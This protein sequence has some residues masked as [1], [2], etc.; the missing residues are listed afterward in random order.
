MASSVSVKTMTAHCSSAGTAE[1]TVSSMAKRRRIQS[2]E[3]WA[4]PGADGCF[5]TGM[6]VY[7]LELSTRELYMYTK[8]GQMYLDYHAA[9]QARA[10]T[11]F[12]RIGKGIFG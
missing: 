5:V 2:P 7:G 3:E 10:P 6:A 12:L 8:E 4:R 11:H 1:F 9:S